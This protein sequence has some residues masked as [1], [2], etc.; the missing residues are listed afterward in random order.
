MTNA[1]VVQVLASGPQD[2]V[3]RKNP[4]FTIWKAA[5]IRYTNYSTD[6]QDVSFQ[7][8]VKFGAN[9]VTAQYVRYADLI[10][11]TLIELTLPALSGYAETN[12]SDEEMPVLGA[13]WVNAIGFAA[14]R[15]VTFEVGGTPVDTLTT[16]DLFMYD[17]LFN[18][19]GHKL[20]EL[21]GKFDYSATVEKDMIEFASRERKLYIPLPF[22]NYI[23]GEKS[24]AVPICAMTRHELKI[25]VAFNSLA[26][27]CVSVYKETDDDDLPYEL[28]T[29]LPTDQSTST[30]IDSTGIEARLLVSYVYISDA[31]RDAFTEQELH[32]LIV[33]NQHMDVSVVAGSTRDQPPMSL[34]HPVTFQTWRWRP[35][36]W[37]TEEG[38]RRYSVGFKDRFDY[39]MK[40][41]SSD[42]ALVW[43]DVQDPFT[44][45]NLKFNNNNRFPA[46]VDPVFFRKFQPQNYA[47]SVFKGFEY[48][49]C[50]AAKVY[51]YNPT[52]TANY[53][54]IEN[55]SFYIEWQ[56]DIPQGELK[57]QVANYNQIIIRKGLLGLRFID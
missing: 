29:H 27:C 33:Q 4:E 32:Y 20:G 21:I 1:A 49:Y 36:N 50:F 14:I 39:S 15:E 52:S 10:E 34:A 5:H 44:A 18:E 48:L 13:Y 7:N 35:T 41:T 3:I 42:D 26:D 19:E 9:K 56:T 28:S 30:T 12:A 38:R 47:K 6:W 2:K 43:E 24:L 11:S 37:N 55:M 57:I 46:E 25:H 16:E 51:E 40:V 23:Y 53:S 8:T 22:Y 54:K 31:E 45:V 17:E